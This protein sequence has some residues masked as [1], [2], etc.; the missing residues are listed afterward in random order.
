M[1]DYLKKRERERKLE[2][3]RGKAKNGNGNGGRRRARNSDDDNAHNTV[4][5]L[6]LYTENTGELYPAVQDVRRALLRA[7]RQ[8]RYDRDMGRAR[9]ATLLKTKAARMYRKEWPDAPRY[10][11]Y[12]FSPDVIEG[13]ADSMANEFEIVA[14]G[15]EYDYLLG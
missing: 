2:K 9:F 13:A 7:M 11:A 8:G 10:G 3:I 12:P 1:S 15:G 5:N 6:K 4:H 14:R